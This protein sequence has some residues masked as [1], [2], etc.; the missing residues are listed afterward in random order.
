MTD[1]DLFDALGFSWTRMGRDIDA[2]RHS[3]KRVCYLLQ[4]QLPV[5][6]WDAGM[7]E[8][9]PFTFVEVKTLMDGITVGG[10]R[11]SDQDQILNL[12]ESHRMLI[13]II[14]NNKFS[15][16]RKQFCQFNK[17]VARN[18][19]L[20]WGCF[21]DQGEEKRC[22]VTVNCGELGVHHPPKTEPGGQNLIALFDHG[23][24][25]MRSAIT[26]PLELASAFFLFGAFQQFF[27]DGNK[28]TSRLMMNG[29]LMSQGLDAISFPAA[30]AQE[31]NARMTRFYI[32][33]NGNE[34]FD[35]IYDLHQQ[36]V[37]LH[38]DTA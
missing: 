30:Q 3:A 33:K 10:R 29:I 25:A 20:E 23:V 12:A 22:S 2:P 14:K 36:A 32:N 21:R 37:N 13:D 34:M 6:V 11:L 8:N 5:F 16:S 1:Q 27:F 31:F 9:N 35:F 38:H 4:R 7:L 17:I 24:G 19:S 15:L 26:S 18:E 28:R